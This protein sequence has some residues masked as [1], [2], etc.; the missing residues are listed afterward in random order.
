ME[1]LG[2]ERCPFCGNTDIMKSKLHEGEYYCKDW[3]GGCGSRL[4]LPITADGLTKGLAIQPYHK[5]AANR[6]DFGETINHLKYW[7]NLGRKEKLELISDAVS[8][9]KK[10]GVIKNLVAAED[11]GSLLIVPAP[12]SKDRDIQHVYAIAQGL[13]TPEYRYVEALLK[14]TC[15][16]SKRKERGS[17]FSE[18]DFSCTY[19]LNGLPTLIVDDTYE[20]GATLRACIKE[21]QKNGAGH[22]YFLSLCKNTGGGIKK[23]GVGT[24][25]SRQNGPSVEVLTEDIP[26]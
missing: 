9:I 21:L 11:L 26:F 3:F 7:K 15:V 14:K 1:F 10:S 2:I 6:S 18:G 25:E 22:I 13:A 12:S 20:E 16:E 23:D 19:T 5:D 17:N 24:A 8:R 4:F